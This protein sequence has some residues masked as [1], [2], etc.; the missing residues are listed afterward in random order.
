[1]NTTKAILEKANHIHDGSPSIWSQS[2][3]VQKA[4]RE[5]AKIYEKSPPLLEKEYSGRGIVICGG[6]KLWPCVWVAIRAIRHHGCDLPIEIWHMGNTEYDKKIMGL[7]S[8]YN[9]K[10]IDAFEY[11]KSYPSRI[12]QNPELCF[13]KMT[14][15]ATM[16]G[17]MLKSYSMLHSS[18]EEVL[19]M[20]ADNTPTKNPEYIFDSK[21]YNDFGAYFFPDKYHHDDEE[22]YKLSPRICKILGIEYEGEFSFDSGQMFVNKSKCLLQLQVAL[23][24]NEFSEY[25]YEI[26]YGDKDTFNLAWR[27]T[28]KKYYFVQKMPIIGH[29]L[30]QFD[31]NEDLIFLHR[32]GAKWTLKKN[33]I[34]NRPQE[35]LLHGFIDELKDSLITL[36]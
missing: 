34:L 11:S 36:V 12:L 27:Q 25:T 23:W 8:P 32:C 2:E 21:Q 30:Q 19:F 13:L 18:F 5:S 20:D 16:G 7:L 14:E 29:G 33:M 22:K 26:I 15:Y 6:G 35:E 17:W 1:M 28:G 9:V 24:W 10:F 31:H 3:D 4:F